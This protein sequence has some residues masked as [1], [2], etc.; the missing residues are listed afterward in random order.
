MIPEIDD[1]V[2]FYSPETQNFG[3]TWVSGCGIL[4]STDRF[5][6]ERLVAKD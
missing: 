1:I 6:S 3:L 5:E 4:A 2:N